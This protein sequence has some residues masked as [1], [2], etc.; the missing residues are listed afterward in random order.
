[1]SNTTQKN[2]A[3]I[4][5]MFEKDIGVCQLAAK[6]KIQATALSMFRSNYRQPK[7]STARKIEKALGKNNLFA[8]VG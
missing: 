6:V 7:Q 4:L 2:K 8:V 1:M 5:A 3:L